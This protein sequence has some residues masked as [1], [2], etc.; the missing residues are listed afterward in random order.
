MA[1]DNFALLAKEIKTVN[2][3]YSALKPKVQVQDENGKVVSVSTEQIA[4]IRRLHAVATIT[5]QQLGSTFS[6]QQVDFRI[7]PGDVQLV[8][9]IALSLKLSN[10]DGSN[11]VT[12]VN[13]A[14][15]WTQIEIW[16][17]GGDTK[18]QTLYPESSLFL[19][20]SMYSTEQQTRLAQLANFTT[21]AYAGETAIGTSA[22]ATYVLPIPGNLFPQI[23]IY[24]PALTGDLIVR[25]FL[26]NG[27]VKAGTGT[28][29]LTSMNLL[30][31][32]QLIPESDKMELLKEYASS[33]QEMNFLDTLQLVKSATYTASTSVS[34]QLTPFLGLCPYMLV[35]FRSSTAVASGV[36]YAFASIG[37]ANTGAAIEIQSSTGT[38]LL[39]SSVYDP[40]YLLSY[41]R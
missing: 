37:S 2:I 4:T 3:P 26:R 23:G 14:F 38:N 15:W 34:E 16:A 33:V 20:G 17:N 21:A 35:C 7:R 12:P 13:S 6:G 25:V 5:P 36:I 31:E 8:R 22:S 24:G 41:D 18:L 32:H 39:Q 19:F 29:V 10:S 1:Q 9:D 27:I 30:V 28:I 40:A 11:T